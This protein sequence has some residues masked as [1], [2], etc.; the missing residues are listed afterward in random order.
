MG[1]G[2]LLRQLDAE[3]LWSRVQVQ[4]L[5]RQCWRTSVE[6][7]NAIF[8]YLKVWHNRR[9]AGDLGIKADDWALT[10]GL[11]RRTLRRK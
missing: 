11:S 8:D 4:P 2:Q 10:G 1:S 7:A 3:A 9:G 6:L 5:D